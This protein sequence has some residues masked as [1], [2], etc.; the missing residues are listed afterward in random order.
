LTA[1][2][3]ATPA[4]RPSR[5]VRGFDLFNTPPAAL[6]PLFEHE[7]LLAGMTTVAEPF[8]VKDNLVVA[9]RERGLTV[10]ASDILD[11]GCP[12]STVLDFRAMT[13]GRRAAAC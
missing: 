7:P 10:F 3:T 6:G 2:A 8:C 12:G 4:L 11:R 5:A 13:D 1:R 9:M